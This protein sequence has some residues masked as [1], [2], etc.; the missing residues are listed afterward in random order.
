MH[1]SLML[2]QMVLSFEHCRFIVLAACLANVGSRAFMGRHMPNVRVSAGE[3]FFA[4][5]AHVRSMTHGFGVVFKL[6]GR[7][8]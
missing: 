6:L 8:K 4:L 2:K 7:L 3:T 1:V 5:L